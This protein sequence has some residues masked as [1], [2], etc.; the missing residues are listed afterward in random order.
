MTLANTSRGAPP[1]S[2]LGDHGVSLGVVAFIFYNQICTFSRALLWRRATPPIRGA[3]S[4]SRPRLDGLTLRIKMPSSAEF[5]RRRR[6]SFGQLWRFITPGL[7]ARE[8]KYIIPFVSASLVFFISGNDRRVL[9]L[10]VTTFVSGKSIGGKSL[11]TEYN[12]NQV[13]DAGSC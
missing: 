7:K 11:L 9:Q 5:W 10:S 6:C 2:R 1:L 8:R 12:P 13:P 4:W 3:R